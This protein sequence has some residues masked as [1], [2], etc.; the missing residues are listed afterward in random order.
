MSEV[1]AQDLK[2]R[3]TLFSW[4]GSDAV[5]PASLDEPLIGDRPDFTESSTTVGYG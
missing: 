2:D 5:G 3:G 4:N 1:S